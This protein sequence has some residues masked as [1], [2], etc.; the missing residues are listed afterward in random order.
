MSVKKGILPATAMIKRNQ[1]S[2]PTE[3]TT[4]TT[5]APAAA[6]PATKIPTVSELWA[7]TEP[8]VNEANKL[9]GLVHSIGS[10]ATLGNAGL[11]KTGNLKM[12][13]A[14]NEIFLNNS[15]SDIMETLDKAGVAPGDARTVLYENFKPGNREKFLKANNLFRNP[16]M[17]QLGKQYGG[18]GKTI[19]QDYVDAI[20]EKYK[21]LK[22]AR[23]A[24]FGTPEAQATGSKKMTLSEGAAIPEKIETMA[25]QK[26]GVR[27]KVSKVL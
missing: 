3:T 16:A 8:N 15:V 6:T 2:T 23:D 9:P 14:G 1:V 26:P 21:Q 22:T 11:D 10:V 19:E 24:Q 17:M 27:L 20:A 18:A 12:K 4:T 13:G 5:V 7:S 25:T